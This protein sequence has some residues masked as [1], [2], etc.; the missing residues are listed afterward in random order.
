MFTFFSTLTSNKPQSMDWEWKEFVE[1]LEKGHTVIPPAQKEFSF[2]FNAAIYREGGLRRTEDCAALSALILDYDENVSI[3][4]ALLRFIVNEKLEFVLYTSFNHQREKTP[5]YIKRD[6]FRVVIPLLTECPKEEWELIKHNL[7]TFAP[8]VDPVCKKINQIYTYTYCA[9]DNKDL[10][11]IIHNPGNKL[12]WTKWEKLK[13]ETYG[14]DSST[15]KAKKADHYLPADYVFRLERGT[16]RF[17]DVDKHISKVYCPHHVDKS[18]G[19]FLDKKGRTVYHVCNKCGTTK[20]EQMIE[21]IDDTMRTGPQ[22]I[23]TKEEVLAALGL[24][25]DDPVEPFSRA[26]RGELIKKRCLKKSHDLMLLYAFEG[27]G[28]SYYA[29][30]EVKVRHSKV[31]FAS[32]SNTQA[33]EQC[34]S[35][36]KAGIKAQFVPGREWK[37]RTQY[38]VDCVYG[39]KQH[40]WDSEDVNEAK[41]K[42]EIMDVVKCTHE[43]AEEIWDDCT[44]PKPDFV[45]YDI[46]CTTIARTMVYGAIQ[47]SKAVLFANAPVLSDEDYIVP[48]NTVV[49]Y[50]DPDKDYFT[51]YEEHTSTFLERQIAKKRAARDDDSFTQEMLTIDGRVVKEIEINERRYFVRPKQF[52]LGYGLFNTRKVFTT[53]ETVTSDLIRKMY[54]DIYE[55]KLMPDQKMRAGNI[56]M[57]KTNMVGAKRD[58]FLPPIMQRLKKEG[59]DFHYFAD[60]QGTTHNLVNTKGQNA[61]LSSDVVIETSEP[62]F[63]IV[64]KYIDEFHWEEGDRNTMKVALALDNLQQAI[65][66]NSGYRWSDEQDYSKRKSAFVLCE[67][68]LFNSLLKFMRYSVETVIEQPSK[69]EGASLK[70]DY[71]TLENGLC[72]FLTYTNRYLVQGIGKESGAFWNDV[73]SVFDGQESKENRKT[74]RERLITALEEM[75]RGSKDSRLTSKIEG[76]L[77]KMLV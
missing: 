42:K 71:I 20:I 37:L 39:K 29:Q 44:S 70:K 74:F 12:D 45:N 26:E 55:P 59:Y 73:M 62:H 7:D 13:E 33:Q 61:F 43:R 68:K 47:A 69:R 72:W 32:Y 54:T 14:V 28:K 60:G 27:F 66:R 56:T 53:T 15:Y 22:K 64:T 58:G 31:L 30:L 18:P 17:C 57:I 6:K 49:F 24:S 10:A 11:R 67:P 25:K 50:D 35:F 23:I 36:T 48:K 65:G 4:D 21:P 38:K 52:V 3:E 41:T 9:E 63:N 40:P 34:E 75:R 51:F 77:E 76:Y 46:V 5:G 2:H 1:Q 19:T 16:V 8:G